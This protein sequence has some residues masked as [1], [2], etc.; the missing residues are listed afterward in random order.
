MNTMTKLQEIVKALE[1]QAGDWFGTEI[2]NGAK[3]EKVGNS[4]AYV[5]GVLLTKPETKGQTGALLLVNLRHPEL[6]KLWK[7]STDDLKARKAQL[8]EELE[9]INNQIEETEK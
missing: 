2:Y 4:C 8:L 5:D 7:Q 9:E 3:V 6:D 1:T